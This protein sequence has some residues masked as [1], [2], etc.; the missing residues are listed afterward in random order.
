MEQ[1]TGDDANV[2][3]V[4]LQ[5]QAAAID[6]AANVVHKVDLSKPSTGD[7]TPPAEGTPPAEDTPPA[8]GTP[9]EEGANT[10]PAEGDGTPSVLEEIIDTPPAEGDE[11]TPPDFEAIQK[12]LEE[13]KAKYANGSTGAEVPEGMESLVEFLADTGGTLEDYV[14]LNQDV[15]S[16]DEETLLRQYHKDLE[17]ELTD[18]EINFVME[19]QYVTDEL[20]DDK[21]I[22]KAALRKKRNISKA[23]KA[24]TDKKEK[25]FKEIKSGS[26]LTPDQ[27]KA[28]EFFNR[29]TSEEQ[30]TTEARAKRQ[31]VF[32]QKTDKFFNDEFK[33]FEYKVGEKKYRFNVKDVAGTKTTQSDINNFTK[34]YLG[35]DK[36]LTDAKGYHKALFT[37]MNAD[38]IADHFYKQGQ[39]DALK[40]SAAKAKNIDM[41]ARG[42]HGTGIP[43]QGGVKAKVVASDNPSPG[44]LRIK[45]WS[46]K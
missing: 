2:V 26:K 19:E 23:K 44:R 6:D 7:D 40:T 43:N 16:L 14:K 34:K 11:G 13:L 37:A 4:N 42:N 24:V 8:E 21:D 10:P 35:D 15:D 39:A 31:E 18:E 5:Q 36:A 25:Y 45:N 3:K 28:V 12:E 20:M 1:N 38:A 46:N 17:P 29:Y 9:P 30:E 22:K 41:N 33:G 32:T 27:Q